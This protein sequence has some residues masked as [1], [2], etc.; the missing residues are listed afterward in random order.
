MAEWHDLIR[1]NDARSDASWKPH[2]IGVLRRKCD[3]DGVKPVKFNSVRAYRDGD[4]YAHSVKIELAPGRLAMPLEQ[5]W[6][7]NYPAEQKD[8]A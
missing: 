3:R 6:D 1:S 5:W 7:E 8:A 4:A 2:H